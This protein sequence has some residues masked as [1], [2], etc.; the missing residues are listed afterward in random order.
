MIAAALF[1]VSVML[2]TVGAW[3][4]DSVREQDLEDL[5]VPRTLH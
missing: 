3:P 2:I 5:D 4:A 1:G